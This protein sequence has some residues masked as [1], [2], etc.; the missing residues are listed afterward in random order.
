MRTNKRAIRTCPGVRDLPPHR[1]DREPGHG[2]AGSIQRVTPMFL[3]T[4][5]NVHGRADSRLIVWGK[6]SALR[7]GDTSRSPGRAASALCTFAAGCRNRKGRGHR[8]RPP[9]HRT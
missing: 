8:A 1:R 9:G 2:S 6:P 3:W 7:A 5:E 4:L